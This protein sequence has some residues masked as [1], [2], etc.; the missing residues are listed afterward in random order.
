M[1]TMALKGEARREYMRAYMQ[2][3][4]A[5]LPTRMVPADEIVCCS[6]CGKI[7]SEVH[8]LMK[9]PDEAPFMAYICDACIES[10]A[11]VVSERKWCRR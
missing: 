11:A 2:R 8:T 5:G 1:P 9:A 7:A 3:R 10:A 4:R 6:F